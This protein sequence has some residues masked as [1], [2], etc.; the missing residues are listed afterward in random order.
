MPP[1]VCFT[2]DYEPDCPPYRSDTH[3]GVE[4]GTAPLL[5]VLR[6][7]GVPAT[8]FSTGEVAERYPDAI[9]A[10]VGAGHELGCHG[11]T[12]RRF[13][14]MTAAEARD[15]LAASSAVLRRFAAVDAFRAPNLA[16]PDACLPL[17]EE[18]G[19][20]LDSSHAKYKAPYW[21]DRRRPAPTRLA[22]IPASLTSSALRLPRALRDA[23][24]A[25]LASPV[26]LF[27]H[28]WEFV[29]W[30]GTDLRLDCRFRTGAPALACMRSAL[31]F[32]RGRG[33]RFVTMREAA[34]GGA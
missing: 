3:R 30:R 20:A 24:L 32:L 27:V 23:W 9:R 28:P 6:E 15:E 10:I 21:R 5:D 17:L 13:D 26:V 2:V 1:L 18:A 19:Y 25:S 4:E 11:H 31:D 22:R 8:F 16:L 33:A 29:D 14:A 34:R 7:A 12:H